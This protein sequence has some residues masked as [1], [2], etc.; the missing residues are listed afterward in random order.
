MINK[1]LP[2]SFWSKL[3]KPFLV[4][5]PMENVTDFVFREVVA[6]YLPR[7]DVFF[8]EFTSAEGIAS[9]KGIRETTK[10]F[11]F[12]NNQRPIVAQI[13]GTDPKCFYKATQVV[14]KLGF[15][16]IDINMG[17]PDRTVMKKGGGAKLIQNYKLVK[18]LILAIKEADS[19]LPLSI[20]TRIG[21]NSVV[22]NEWTSFLLEQKISALT[23]HGRT[24]KQK[25]D[26]LA[27]WAEIQK[28]VIIKNKISPET[29]VIGNGDVKDY[30]EAIKKHQS[31]GVDGVMIGRGIFSNPWVFQK[32]NQIKHSKSEYFQI[33]E[34]HIKLFEK[35]YKG[36]ENFAVIKKF[37]KM[38]I[39]NF[40]H[41]SKI[42]Q[43]LM[44][45][46]S[47]QEALEKIQRL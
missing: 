29:I 14:S 12:S 24:A 4:L 22:T 39:N 36:E 38:Y 15:D 7:P 16:G 40:K 25:S 33:L 5:A 9:E 1:K 17:C 20:K 19:N 35:T 11:L 44:D 31:Y 6:K 32:D 28:A 8:T 26:G 18:E 27:D 3:K 2:S 42:R 10:R 23:I 46:K 47:A 45:V 34:R 30:T 21:I 37:F 13:W 41:A 43:E